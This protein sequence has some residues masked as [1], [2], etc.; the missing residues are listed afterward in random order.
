MATL[1][2]CA[3]DPTGVRLVLSRCVSVIV[4]TGPL[5]PLTCGPCHCPCLLRV[6]GLIARDLPDPKLAGTC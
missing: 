2:S 4:D 6:M 3:E 1:I 5:G